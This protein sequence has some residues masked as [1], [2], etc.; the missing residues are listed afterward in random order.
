MSTGDNGLD[1]LLKIGSLAGLAS[2]LW[3]AI[4]DLLKL[5]R[6][7]KLHITFKSDRDL[8]TF[9]YGAEGWNRKFVNLHIENTG[10]ETARRCVAVMSIVKKP[11]RR[12]VEDQY[13]LHWASLPLSGLTTGAEP[14]DI[15]SHE[16]A[17]LDVLFT[18]SG[19]SLQGCWV[20]VPFALT[21]N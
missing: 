6:K 5:S 13:S 18:Q 1:I 3:L 16:L 10:K 2:F 11:E 4:K 7:P 21:G 19:Q 17:R 9:I 15:G 8:R 14:I 20:P 12:V